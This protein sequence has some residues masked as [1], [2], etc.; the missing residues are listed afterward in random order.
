MR[1]WPERLAELPYRFEDRQAGQSKM[2]L[3]E[4]TGYLAQLRDLYLLRIFG[5]S[6]P[7]RSYRRFRRGEI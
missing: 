1:A 3:R 2:S 7:Q 6:R 5:G 4:A